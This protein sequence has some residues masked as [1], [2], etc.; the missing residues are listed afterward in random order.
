VVRV[1]IIQRSACASCKIAEHCTSS[2]SK[3]KLIDVRCNN[4]DRYTVGQE[5]TVMAAA[6]VGAKAVI[7]A[8]VIP[9]VIMMAVIVSIIAFGGSEL[10]AAL[11]GM[12]VLIPYLTVLYLQ[13]NRMERILTF[14]MND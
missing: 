1:R 6:S 9:V 5:V 11:A 14:Y 13:R 8:F 3:E 10:T 7:I 4:A 12:L 2:E